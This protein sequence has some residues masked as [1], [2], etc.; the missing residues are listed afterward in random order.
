MNQYRDGYESTKQ[1]IVSCTIGTRN[2]VILGSH[3]VCITS[4]FKEH[5]R[6]GNKGHRKIGKVYEKN[7]DKLTPEN[8]NITCI[9]LI[10]IF[11]THFFFIY[12]FTVLC[13]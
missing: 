8:S 10:P 6:S 4:D 11:S 12:F 1:S 2:G 5:I 3:L 9:I 7:L 13:S